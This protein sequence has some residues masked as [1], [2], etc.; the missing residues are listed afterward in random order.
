MPESMTSRLRRAWDVFRSR[1]PTSDYGDYGG[2]SVV[3][4][5]SRP[6]R[7]PISRG[8]ERT[9]LNSIYNRMAL[10]VSTSNIR[11][12]KTDENGRYLEDIDDDLN[13]CLK[14][15]CNIDQTGR[16]MIQDLCLTMFDK[17]LVA[18]VPVITDKDPEITDAFK[19]QQIR[20]GT[21]TQWKPQ[22][23]KV[24]LF[25]E[26][27]NKC[28][29]VWL[30]KKYVAIIQNPFYSIMNDK[31]SSMQR[32]LRK[33]VLLD[34]VDEQSS[35]GK[36]DMI[37][38][39]PYTIKTEAKRQSAEQRR[40]DIEMQLTGSKYGIAY[41]DGTEKVIQLNRPVEN[42]LLSQVEYL[43]NQVMSQLGMTQGILDGTADEQTMTNYS[44]R[45][46]AV[47]LTAIVEEFQRKWLSKTARTQGQAIMF[48]NDPFRF[49]PVSKMAEMVD[50]F[51]RN[52]ILS[53]NECRQGIGFK[54]SKD[55]AA[56]ELR[57]KNLS[58][59][60]DTALKPAD[61]TDNVEEENQ[62]EA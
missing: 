22:Y 56:D 17:G 57:N 58:A 40:K 18:A 43:T 54:P 7:I 30:N 21:I 62:N 55:P 14:I 34:M 42:N 6:D 38:Q 1:E 11:H 39:L 15:E 53:S 48:F 5:N 9:I 8:S 47:I 20:I 28:E 61:A 27:T 24:S 26:L 4:T 2:Y 25:N 50:K 29:E 51:T 31:N 44:T 16:N 10:D 49:V 33:L 19:V 13:Y 59:P 3:T 41:T 52:E 35:S 45:I 23:V 32:L 36:L 37:I 46:T 60:K 12:V